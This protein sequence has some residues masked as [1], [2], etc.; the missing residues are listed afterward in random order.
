MMFLM[1]CMTG[2][3]DVTVDDF[4]GEAAKWNIPDWALEK[5]DH[6]AKKLEL[7]KEQASDGKSSLKIETAFPGGSWTAAVVEL[8]DY[9]DF[10]PAQ[11]VAVD[12]YIP[13][14][15]PEGLK[16]NIVL[17][18]GDGWT[19]TEQLRPV[20][21]VPGKWTTVEANIADGSKD[22][23]KAKVDEMWRSDIRKVDIRVISD[24][25]PAY[26]GPVYIDNMRAI[27]SATNANPAATPVVK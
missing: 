17:T 8:E 11:K 26:S 21:L 19:W 3:A 9:L 1:T 27:G 13:A 24:K 16:G 2:I 10:S 6:V 5:A 4:E 14:D 15:A 25:K 22:W 12:I 20:A 18:I 23:K 7:S